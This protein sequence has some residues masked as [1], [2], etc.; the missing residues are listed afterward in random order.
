MEETQSL[1]NQKLKKIS[2]HSLNMSFLQLF[3]HWVFWRYRSSFRWRRSGRSLPPTNN[4]CLAPAFRRRNFNRGISRMFFDVTCLCLEDRGRYIT[5]LNNALLKRKSLKITIHV[6]CSNP[7]KWVVQWPLEDF[8]FY[9]FG[10]IG[11]ICNFCHPK[12][13]QGWFCALSRLR[14][15]FQG[16][17]K[18]FG[19]GESRNG[20]VRNRFKSCPPKNDTAASPNAGNCGFAPMKS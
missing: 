8:N 5:N 12:N 13:F 4:S 2:F 19:S 9:F 17:M 14:Q 10:K 6:L 11:N 7:R 18:I 3:F 15:H 1:L 20:Q 16:W